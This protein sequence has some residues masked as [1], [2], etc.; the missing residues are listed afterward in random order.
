MRSAFPIVIV[1]G[2]LSLGLGA[3]LALYRWVHDDDSL[4]AIASIGDPNSAAP[5]A[6]PAHTSGPVGAP[7]TL[8]EFS[9]FQ[10]APCGELHEELKKLRIDYGASLC[11]IF[12]QFPIPSKN[13]QALEAARASE[14]AALQGRFW[15]MHDMLY[16]NQAEWSAAADARP[17]FVGYARSL[18]LDVERFLEDMDGSRAAARIRADQERG[19]SIRVPGTPIVFLNGRLLHPQMLTPE[20]L[21]KSM[22]AALAER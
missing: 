11:V 2:G 5:G 7:L 10:C 15:E 12:R 4:N 19:E 6:A 1:A 16:E 8:E 9:D 14:S 21:R 17:M 18:G 3:G 22:D 13:R 20:G